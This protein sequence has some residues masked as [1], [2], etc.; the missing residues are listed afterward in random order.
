[1]KLA[2][3]L[4]VALAVVLCGC[5]V[6][7]R[8]T[9]AVEPPIAT[10]LPRAR[11]AE[12]PPAPTPAKPP[13]SP[14][15]ASET[16]NL[17]AYYV[18]VRRLAPPE[19]AREYENARQLYTKSRAD[20]NRVRYASVASVPGTPFSDDARALEALEPL[21]RNPDS[22]FHSI[23]YIISVQI[24]EQRRSAGLQQKLDALMSLDKSLLERE[25]AAPRRR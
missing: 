10:P 12:T 13:P 6:K 7:G 19:L 24:S 21:L 17:L 4:G 16:E 9:P 5:A 18:T 14:P 8:E 23:A 1:M 2:V 20:S 25:Q 3:S 15:R 11:E 22:A